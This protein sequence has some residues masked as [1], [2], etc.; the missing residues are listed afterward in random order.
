M[1]SFETTQRPKLQTIF[2]GESQPK[3]SQDPGQ[4]ES[5]RC[6]ALALINFQMSEVTASEGTVLC[7]TVL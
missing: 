7:C 2:N 1:K 4:T 3:A 6:D 5:R